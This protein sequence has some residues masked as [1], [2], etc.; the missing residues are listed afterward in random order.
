[1]G[2]SSLGVGNNILT[3]DVIDQLRKADE[4]GRIQPITLELANE[5]D[6]QEIR[7]VA[8]KFK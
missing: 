3:Q 2:I 6:K 7:E 5:N 4:A 8:A 1:M